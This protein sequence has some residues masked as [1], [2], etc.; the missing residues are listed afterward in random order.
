M[1]LRTKGGSASN[2]NDKGS[3]GKN[4]H[5]E[6]FTAVMKDSELIV[7]AAM[8]AVGGVS[9]SDFDQNNNVI[10]TEKVVD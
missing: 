2:A 1:L 4:L 3:N 9:R 6:C 7:L 5:G 8:L 10:V